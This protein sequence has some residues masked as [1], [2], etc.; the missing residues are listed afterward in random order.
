MAECRL[1]FFCCGRKAR[2][3]VVKKECASGKFVRSV[4][5]RH[6]EEHGLQSTEGVWKLTWFLDEEDISVDFVEA[7]GIWVILA[8]YAPERADSAL[9][10]RLLR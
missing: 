3:T 8:P 6:L 9:L 1:R 4:R 10:W 7:P 2:E 5:F